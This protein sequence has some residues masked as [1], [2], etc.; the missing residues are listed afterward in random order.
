MAKYLWLLLAVGVVGP[1]WAQES[2]KQPAETISDLAYPAALGMAAWHLCASNPARQET[3]RRMADGLIITSL[4]T[5]GLKEAVHSSRPGSAD[6]DDDGFP[7]GHTAVAFA[8]AAALSAREPQAKWIAF[9]V[10]AAVG[11][12]REDLGRHTWA[13]VLGGAVLGAYVGHQAGEGKLT[14]FG[15]NDADLAPAATVAAVGPANQVVLWG[16]Q[17]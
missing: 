2:D 3:G 16:T 7:S 8:A 10:A 5:L 17:F 14:I 11:W 1:S 15:H 13:Q 12:A 9:P 6:G 4:L